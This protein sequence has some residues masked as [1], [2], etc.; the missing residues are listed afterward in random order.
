MGTGG[1]L[2]QKRTKT[3]KTTKQWHPVVEGVGFDGIGMSVLAIGCSTTVQCVRKLPWGSVVIP[4]KYVRR[5][6]P[7]L[8]H[9]SDLDPE[10][11]LRT[12]HGIVTIVNMVP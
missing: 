7:E 9:P 5:S 11:V 3:T 10:A 2:E 6:P 12:T 8:P 4:A 1:T